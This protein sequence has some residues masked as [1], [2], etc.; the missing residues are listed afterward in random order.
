MDE[1]Q[2]KQE[3]KEEIQD[4]FYQTT[5]YED[6]ESMLLNVVKD[7]DDFNE[8]ED[9]QPNY[10]DEED[11]RH[12]K[13]HCSENTEIVFVNGEPE[14]F[15]P[16]N[17]QQIKEDNSDPLDITPERSTSAA[18]Q[19]IILSTPLTTEN[20]ES[21]KKI[22]VV[23][24]MKKTPS[25]KDLV[26]KTYSKK[27]REAPHLCTVCKKIFSSANLLREHERSCFKCKQCN[28]IVA[29]MSHLVNHM[30]KCRR[31]RRDEPT[32]LPSNKQ[33]RHSR[34]MGN[35]SCNICSLTFFSYKELVE[36]Q[37]QNH[38]TPNA[39]AC[40]ICDQKFDSEIE[41]LSHISTSH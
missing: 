18:I 12:S 20:R 25:V 10:Q 30:R 19:P 9:N 40:H 28:L 33:T 14:I 39:Y 15:V 24:T 21:F 32:N 13:V 31:K 38:A 17:I 35:K 41:A 26:Q 2:I 3:I 6:N 7:E 34:Y 29:N 1:F 5:E 8:Y 23:R 11:S 36:H 16:M 4:D 27:H 22:R 37:R